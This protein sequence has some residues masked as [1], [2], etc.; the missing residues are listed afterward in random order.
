MKLFLK[1]ILI[2][3]VIVVCLFFVLDTFVFPNN[4]NTYNY[5]A[6]LLQNKEVEVLI[7]GNSHL[8]F[9]VF[10]DS[11][12]NF[13]T[14]N[15]ATKAREL[16]T[17]IDL[18]VSNVQ[19]KEKLKAVLIPISYYSL[20]GELSST[21]EYHQSQMRL[22]YNFFKLE[23]YDQGFIKNS[24]IINEPFRELMNDSFFLSFMKKQ[25]ISKKGWRANNTLFVKDPEI[26][27]KL[28]R[29]KESI[30]NKSLIEKNIKRIK[31]LNTECNINNVKLI[32]VLPPYSAY[33]Y[34]LTNHKYNKIINNI[35][36]ENL[37]DVQVL[38]AVN[39]MPT[40]LEYYENSDH[41]NVKGAKLF[42]KKLDSILKLSL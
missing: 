31:E 7:S 38:D 14:V 41:L 1:N 36:S 15:I 35:L 28:K 12:F 10:A 22:Y 30:K 24:L 17:D 37:K 23:K 5:K 19:N 8:G 27:G 40:D 42:T 4:K 3:S 16:N 20:F 21:N 39:F 9:G 18:L 26:I 33:F 32:L 2:L 34:S 6:S 29:L 13:N 25:K 11:I